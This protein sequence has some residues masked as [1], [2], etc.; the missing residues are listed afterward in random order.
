MLSKHIYSC[1]P[2]RF[3]DGISV[4]VIKAVDTISLGLCHHVSDLFPYGF[5][6][7][8]P[9]YNQ[10]SSNHNTFDVLLCGVYYVIWGKVA[11]ELTE[12]ESLLDLALKAVIEA[13]RI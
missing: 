6:Q 11:R 2:H 12:Q 3:H 8:F 10:R 1:K 5:N 9:G 13:L 4:N 7:S